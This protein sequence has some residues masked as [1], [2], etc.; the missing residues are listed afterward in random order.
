[1]RRNYLPVLV[2]GVFVSA[3]FFLTLDRDGAVLSSSAAQDVIEQEAVDNKPSEERFA[4]EDQLQTMSVKV[5]MREVEL[6]IEAAKLEA[7]KSDSE[8][9]VMMDAAKAKLQA[10]ET[11][12]KIMQEMFAVGQASQS[13]MQEM[14]M[15]RTEARAEVLAIESQ[16]VAREKQLV[17]FEQTVELAELKVK[18]AVVKRDQLSRKLHRLDEQ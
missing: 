15:K 4:L 2:A 5:A 17:V 9:E 13:E 10:T 3:L 1:M 14:Q 16:V 12:L 11:Q 6:R 7:F 8:A 18:L